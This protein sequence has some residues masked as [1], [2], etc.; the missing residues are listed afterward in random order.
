MRYDHDLFGVHAVDRDQTATGGLAL[1][2]GQRRCRH[3]LIE[4][5]TLMEAGV[6]QHRVQPGDGT[7]TASINW[8]AAF[9]SLCPTRPLRLLLKP[10]CRWPGRFAISAG[11][12]I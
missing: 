12:G 11:R 1:D 6:T 4:D 2:D 7:C 3:H 9:C 8:S 10:G 5:A